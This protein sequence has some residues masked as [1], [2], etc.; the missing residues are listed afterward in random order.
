MTIL[1]AYDGSETADAA[2]AAAA[3]PHVWQRGWAERGASQCGAGLEPL[4]LRPSRLP[5]PW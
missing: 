1:F 5:R 2:I 4:S 3:G